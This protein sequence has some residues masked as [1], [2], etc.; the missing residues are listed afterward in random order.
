MKKFIP[1]NFL[2]DLNNNLTK[3]FEDQLKGEEYWDLLEKIFSNT[4]DKHA[5]LRLRSRKET[6]L[7]KKPWITKNLLKSI[8][9]KKKMYKMV[10]KS[11][12]DISWLDYK[13]FR[14]KLTHE[15]EDAKRT[16]FKS[17]ILTSKSDPKKLW[18]NLNEIV[19]LKSKK[20]KSNINELKDEDL[21]I[22]EPIEICN[23]LNNFFTDV[24]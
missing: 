1:E 13:K 16:Y 19:N 9:L 20:S 8:K 6:K 3:I 15:I 23:H 7:L 12:S 24:G 4:L 21:T 22:T 2:L 17:K 18:Q 5:P 14:N 11:S 10:L